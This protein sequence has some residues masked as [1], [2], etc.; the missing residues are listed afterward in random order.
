MIS[1][2]LLWKQKVISKEI[3]DSGDI[4]REKYEVVFRK[5]NDECLTKIIVDAIDDFLKSLH[6]N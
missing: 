1:L 3:V 6:D 4:R 5:I 2:Y